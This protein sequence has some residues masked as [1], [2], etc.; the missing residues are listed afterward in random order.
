MHGF[1]IVFPVL[2]IFSL[3]RTVSKLIKSALKPSKIPHDE[4]PPVSNKPQ[5]PVVQPR[6]S[7]IHTMSRSMTIS[8]PDST[9][10]INSALSNESFQTKSSMSTS[11]YSSLAS[12]NNSTEQKDITNSAEPV[13]PSAP[14]ISARRGNAAVGT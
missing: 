12:S 14:P 11:L 7:S 9:Q 10:I 1:V 5:L 4:S 3:F 2:F 8:N 6:P 13:T